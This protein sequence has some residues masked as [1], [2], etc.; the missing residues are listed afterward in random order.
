MAIIPKSQA[1]V[2][3]GLLLAATEAWGEMQVKLSFLAGQKGWLVLA[4]VIAGLLL[5]YFTLRK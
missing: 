1:A 5:L 4:G 2:E 3:Y